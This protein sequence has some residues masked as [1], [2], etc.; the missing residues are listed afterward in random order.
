VRLGEHVLLWGSL[1]LAAFWQ[2]G[3]ARSRSASGACDVRGP[4]TQGYLPELWLE[5]L[6]TQS[7]RGLSLTEL[8]SRARDF[9][10]SDPRDKVFALLG[11]AN[12]LG[13]AYNRAAGL[14]P[15]Y[16]LRKEEVY[17]NFTKDL[18]LMTGYLDILSAVDTFASK[19]LDQRKTSWTPDLDVPIATVRGLGFPR[20]YAA[21]SSAS[22]NLEALSAVPNDPSSLTLSGFVV[23]V[24]KDVADNALSYSAQLKLYTSDFHHDDAVVALWKEHVRHSQYQ[25]PE[26]ELLQRY[27]ELLTAAGFALPTEFPAHPLGRIIPSRDVP[28]LT[29]DFAAYWSL[30]DPGFLD[31]QDP[32]RTKLKAQ[33]SLG[34]ADQFGVLAGKACHERKFFGTAQG[35]MG[36]CPRGTQSGDRIVILHGGSVPY[37]LREMDYGTWRF[38]GECYVDGIMFGEAGKMEK[39][40][41]V[42]RIM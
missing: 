37:V 31:F 33:A 17:A 18:I 3:F 20:K 11:L 16:T 36:L 24:V 23:D 35:R 32:V 7:E 12:D 21:S 6:Y 25:C 27:I 19:R 8:V 29:A 28:S 5:L 42:Y 41:K 30:L 38:I 34:D 13:D 22:V 9:E 10:A 1:V 40:E 26:D 14:L 39:E 15:N 4:D 2:S